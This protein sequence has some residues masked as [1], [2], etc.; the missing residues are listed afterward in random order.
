V[1]KNRANRATD[2]RTHY[3]QRMQELIAIVEKCLWLM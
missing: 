3:Y 1:S 2:L